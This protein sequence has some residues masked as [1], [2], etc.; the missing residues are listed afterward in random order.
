MNGDTYFAIALPVAIVLAIVAVVLVVLAVRRLLAARKGE[1]KSNK[2]LVAVFGVLG[3]ALIVAAVAVYYVACNV[4]SGPLDALFVGGGGGADVDSTS[5]D[6]LNLAHEI[7]NEGMVLL[8][9]E[10]DTLPLAEGTKVNLLGYCGW[11][12]VYSGAG[13]GQVSS[14]GADSFYSALTDAGFEVNT[15][16]IDEAV[17]SVEEATDETGFNM[18]ETF[19]IPEAKVS[20]FKGDAAFEKMAEFSDTA[21]VVIG[22]SGSE[23]R[24][25]T[26]F[27]G[28]SGKHY[29][30]LSDAEDELVKK[31]ADTFEH[32]ILVYNGGNALELGFVDEYGIDAAI[33]AGIP[34]PH[35]LVAFANI[36]AGT[37]NPSGKLPDTYAYDVYSAAAMENFGEQKASN[38]D[39]YYVD[40][41]ENVYVGYKW[42]ETAYAEGAKI[43]SNKSGETYDFSDYESVVQYPFGY[44]LSYT[45]FEQKI[46]SVSSDKIDPMG[47]TTVTVEVKNTGD[48]AGKCAVQLYFSSPYT[49]YDKQN[50]VEK[51][52]VQLLTIGKTK[53]LEP[54]ESETIELNFKNEVLA[55][56]DMSHANADGT[57]GCYM[58]DAGD[59]ILSLR[60][61]SHTEIESK[62]ISLSDQF[63]YEGDNKRPSDE[64][65]ATNQMDFA[66]RGIYLS[67]QNGF[68]NYQEAMASVVDTVDSAV[69]STNYNGY[70]PA[71]DT[72]PNIPELVEGKDYSN[73][74]RTLTFADLEGAAY[75]DERWDELISYMR[76]KDLTTLLE[77]MY[78]TAEIGLIKKPNTKSSDGP[79]GINSMF[80]T[81]DENISFPCVPLMAATFNLE[82]AYQIGVYFAD[83]AHAAAV[84]T[85]YGPAMDIHRT[86]FSGRNFEY[87]SEDG[88]LAALYAAAEVKGARDGG[89]VATIKHFALNDQ[90]SQ[91]SGMLHTYTN[92]Q[93][94]REIY[95]RP[96]EDCIKYG[97]ATEIMSAMNYVG[98]KWIGVCSE[99]QQNIVRGEWGFVGAILTDMA[100]GDYCTGSA[101][102]AL[103]AGTDIWLSTGA[104]PLMLTTESNA[105]IYYLQRAA[106]NVLYAEA[107]AMGVEAAVL[108][109]R[110]VVCVACGALAVMGVAGFIAAASNVIGKKKEVAA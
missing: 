64:V 85:W 22:R 96:F 80:T 47:E 11:N 84:T 98:D 37:V 71:Y 20:D 45:T 12:P 107:N 76:P 5:E 53:L 4:Y 94:A 86:A 66:A 110:T 40:Y 15:A 34:G 8:K 93:A 79:L 9:N 35:G 95:F 19:T 17:Y 14:V 99:I 83:Q 28:D 32:V 10:E 48:V 70:D 24:D 108:P 67:R 44:G 59:Y 57:Q 36:L 23:E 109:W 41:V 105:D 56:Y 3:A 103:R 16:P 104:N 54:G 18:T 26:S 27:E 49:D 62:T 73:P 42:Y 100:Q 50:G 46:A 87:Y 58:L 38:A 31:A 92:E 72:D 43:K 1:A 69:F 21:I 63:F 30:E 89:L 55:S 6:W 90:E 88:V 33:W 39:E 65:V 91:R 74:D 2:A 60:S 7:G 68:A 97:D 52:A 61:D 51:A 77:C 75:D 13:S 78:N 81:G 29:L 101:D 106:K 102:W 25:L 82:I